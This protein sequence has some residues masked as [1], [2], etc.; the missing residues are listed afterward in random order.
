[1]G[2]APHL[3]GVFMLMWLSCVLVDMQEAVIEELRTIGCRPPTWK[4]CSWS[5]AVAPFQRCAPRL[6]PSMVPLGCCLL[7]LHDLQQL[8]LL[9]VHRKRGE[10]DGGEVLS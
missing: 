2:A 1:M 9:R 3:E 6:R 7:G 5:V 4:L 8:L 10:K